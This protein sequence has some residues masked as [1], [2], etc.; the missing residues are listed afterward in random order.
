[1]ILNDRN[2]V[3]NEMRELSKPDLSA[4]V[5]GQPRDNN[6]LPRSGHP[7]T[8]LASAAKAK[9]TDAPKAKKVQ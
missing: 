5:E 9:A 6:S 7:N 8:K 3:L 4:T 1:V 2:R